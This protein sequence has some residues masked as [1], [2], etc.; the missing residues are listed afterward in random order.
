MQQDIVEIRSALRQ[1]QLNLNRD[2]QGIENTIR[3]ILILIWPLLWAIGLIVI[4]KTIRR[5]KIE[6]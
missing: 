1:V 2:I 6:Y 5:R 3:L 4:V